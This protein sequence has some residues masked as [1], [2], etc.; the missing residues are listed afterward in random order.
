MRG[1]VAGPGRLGFT[2]RRVQAPR[3]L[4]KTY[5]VEYLDAMRFLPL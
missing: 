2:H 4:R 3:L 1:Q 5:F